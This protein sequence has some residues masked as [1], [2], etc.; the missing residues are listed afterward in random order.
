VGEQQL[1]RMRVCLT[2][3]VF[4]A[5]WAHL[6]WEHL[7]GGVVRHHILHRPELP[8]I[9][10]WWGALLLPALAWFLLGRIHR[11]MVSRADQDRVPSKP[12]VGVIVGFVG[13]LTCGILLAASFTYHYDA[14]ASYLFQGALLLALLL[15]V[16]RAE[17]V[18]GFVLGMTPT[19]GA[20]LP[21]AVGS[22]IAALSAVMHLAV[23]PVFARLRTRLS[24]R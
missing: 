8:A 2:G 20:L 23:R 19:F 16:Y 22:L 17:C 24:R 9:S 14:L 11:R 7:H 15:P 1:S 12:T 3:V 13:A 6:I 4:L 18:L 21:T 10:N 5:E